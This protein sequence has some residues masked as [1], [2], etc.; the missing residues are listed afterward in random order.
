MRENEVSKV[1]VAA[2]I[3][4]RRTLGG[5]GLMEPNYEEARAEEL[6]RRS[7]RVDRQ[8]PVPIVYNEKT[9]RHPLR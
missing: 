9:L 8:L 3:E 4:V 5:P 6:Q 2:A 7:L 1:I